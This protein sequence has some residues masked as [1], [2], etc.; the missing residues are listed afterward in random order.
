M[1]DKIN[2]EIAY[3]TPQRQ[4]ILECEFELGSEARAAVSGSGIEQH[5]PEIDLHSCDI[6]IF[7]KSVAD[8]HKL[9]DGDRI[10]IYRPLIADPKEIR[11]QRAAKG[12]KMKKGG[13]AVNSAE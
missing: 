4:L 7:G 10:E 6:G 8:D 1:N 5:F 12:L 9:F 2:V 13:G 11:R 3:A